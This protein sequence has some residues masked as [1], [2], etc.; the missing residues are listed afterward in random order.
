MKQKIKMLLC[1]LALVSGLAQ[2]AEVTFNP[3]VLWYNTTG[4]GTLQLWGVPESNG[5]PIQANPDY[6]W[7]TENAV[8]MW[9]SMLMKAQEMGK[10][11]VIGYNPAPPYDLW[12]IGRPR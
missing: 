11:V 8:A 6:G 4:D 10:S 5:Q 12:Y 9:L 3:N 1:A 7:P 2:P